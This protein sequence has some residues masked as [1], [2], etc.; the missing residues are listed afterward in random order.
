MKTYKVEFN[1]VGI[2]YVFARDFNEVV[3][4]FWKHYAS[5]YS[6]FTIKSITLLGEGIV[7]D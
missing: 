5:N 3:T 7:T 6:E 1:D 4:K 2:V